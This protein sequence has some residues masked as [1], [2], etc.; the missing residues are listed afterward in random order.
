MAPNSAARKE[1]RTTVILTEAQVRRIREVAMAND[2]SIAWVL[3]Q[4][5]DRYLA[6]KFPDDRGAKAASRSRAGKTAK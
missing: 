1:F 5:V 3:R 2:A 4:A 6:A